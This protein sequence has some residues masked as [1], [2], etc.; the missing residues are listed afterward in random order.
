MV[1]SEGEG[2]SCIPEIIVCISA[3]LKLELVS[4]SC[5]GLVKI[6]GPILRVAHSVGV[7]WDPRMCII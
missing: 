7:G 2:S 3:V 5:G 6:T 4:A 1:W